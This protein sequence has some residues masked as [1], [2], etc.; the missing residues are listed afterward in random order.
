MSQTGGIRSEIKSF[1]LPQTTIYRNS[2]KKAQQANQFWLLIGLSLFEYLELG[3][4]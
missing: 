1:R 4:T 2:M 3:L